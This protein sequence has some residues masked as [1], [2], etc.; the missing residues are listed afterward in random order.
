MIQS[1]NANAI[2]CLWQL[3]QLERFLSVWF[4][5]D[6]N[7]DKVLTRIQRICRGVGAERMPLLDGFRFALGKG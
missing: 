4:S 5:V 7:R 3:L 2:D 1:H 6:L